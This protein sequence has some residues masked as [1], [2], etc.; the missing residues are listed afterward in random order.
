MEKSSDLCYDNNDNGQKEEAAVDYQ[1][2]GVVFGSW[3]IGKELGE[4]G[5]GKVFELTKEDFGIQVRSALKVM[6]IPRSQNDVRAALSEGMDHDSVTEMYR[7]VVDELVKEIAILSS[8]KSHPNIVRYEDHKVEKKP[9]GIGWDILIRMELLTPFNDYLLRHKMSEPDVI[10]LGTELAGAVQYCHDKGLIHRDIKPENTFVDDIG[11]FKL[12]DFGI[13]RHTEKTT[14]SMSFKGTAP[15][16]APEVYL[17]KHYGKT[18]DI[19]SLGLMMYKLLNHGRLPFYPLDQ[20]VLS[21]DDRMKAQERR[22]RG[23]SLPK[24]A[25]ASDALSNVILQACA[26]EPAERFQSAKAL[27]EALRSVLTGDRS[28]VSFSAGDPSFE[29]DGHTIPVGFGEKNGGWNNSDETDPA[30]QSSDAT[31]PIGKGWAKEKE[32]Y[33]QPVGPDGKNDSSRKKTYST[34]VGTAPQG[35]KSGTAPDAPQKVTPPQ[36][37]GKKKTGGPAIILILL[38]AAFL[39]YQFL[40]RGSAGSDTDN[41]AASDNGLMTSEEIEQVSFCQDLYNEYTSGIKSLPVD[42]NTGSLQDIAL[43]LQEA[44]WAF[45][46][47]PQNYTLNIGD[48]TDHLY[49]VPSTDTGYS[50]SVSDYKSGDKVYRTVTF[51]GYPYDGVYFGDTSELHGFVPPNIAK[52]LGAAV[53]KDIGVTET[54]QQNLIDLDRKYKANLRGIQFGNKEEGKVYRTW[55]V[56]PDQWNAGTWAQPQGCLLQALEICYVDNT[57]DDAIRFSATNIKGLISDVSYSTVL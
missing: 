55:S 20:K 13:A 10:R 25:E 49:A 50:L 28:A 14:G 33:R 39:L 57:K 34:P 7:Q 16:M 21:Y 52:L 11:H 15:Y 6:Q 12:G 36:P 35:Q 42:Y 48:I 3:I 37:T 38:A 41:A 23:E 56:K 31:S 54:D 30:D 43:K 4:G 47:S 8:V 17:G 1:S 26:Y 2:G 44:G 19:Y 24:P 5:F 9:D 53:W 40:G 22:L 46:P 18:V 29:S 27:Q 51:G 32:N 45:G